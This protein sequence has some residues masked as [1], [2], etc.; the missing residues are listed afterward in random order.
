MKRMMLPVVAVIAALSLGAGV[1]VGADQP[2][3]K[4]PFVD[5]VAAKLGV[6][7]E[8]LREAIQAVLTERMAERTARINAKIDEAV[9][10]GKLSPEDAAKKK[11]LL[12]QLAE[13][14]TS[15]KGAGFF[16]RGFLKRGFFEHG[17]AFKSGGTKLGLL[18]ALAVELEMDTKEL[19]AQLKSGKKL[20]E[21]V[22]AQ[23]KSLDTV[24][25]NVEKT[26]LAAARAK[27]DAA[28]AKKGL[29]AEQAAGWLDK[30]T[31]WVDKVVDRA[32]AVPAKPS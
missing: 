7:P 25:A 20:S 32:F 23:G 24:K 8:K 5:A 18:G 6:S 27:L 4:T 30:L 11:E 3:K 15:G 2:Q 22:T 9:K 29:S 26:L 12:Q 14:L 16:K 17:K 10:A 13:R 19:Y 28:V 1:A 21:I 31:Q